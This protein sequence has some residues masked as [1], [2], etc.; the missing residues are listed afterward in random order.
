M[1]SYLITYI[2]LYTYNPL[3]SF[4]I[5]FSYWATIAQYVLILSSW[6]LSWDS[7]ALYW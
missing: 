2:I 3:Q 4:T 5:L 7:F 6:A 1:M